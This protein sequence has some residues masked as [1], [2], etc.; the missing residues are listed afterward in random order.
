MDR[1]TLLQKTSAGVAALSPWPPLPR[2]AETAAQDQPLPEAQAALAMLD[3]YLS[4][5]VCP[6][7]EVTPQWLQHQRVVALCGAFGS[8]SRTGA[9]SL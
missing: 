9:H 3:E 6:S 1:R 7:T 8:V 2:R 4:L 5:N